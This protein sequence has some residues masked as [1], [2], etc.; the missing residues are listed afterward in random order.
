MLYNADYEWLITYLDHDSL[1]SED[2]LNWDDT[3]DLLF[4]DYNFTTF[5]TNSFFINEHI[6]LDNFTKLSFLDLVFFVDADE[7]YTQLEFYNLVMWDLLVTAPITFLHLQT[8]FYA[9]YQDLTVLILY[10]SPEL[11]LALF[12]YIETYWLAAQL[13]SESAAVFD[14]YQDSLLL[15][16]PNLL[17]TLYLYAC[18]LE[19]VSTFMIH[20]L[21]INEVEQVTHT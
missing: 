13:S 14:V 8:L 5:L 2:V 11:V 4:S 1:W 7:V 16:F 18:L 20:L 19:V 15:V 12:S 9:D 3:F 6:F 10:H 17:K 21:L